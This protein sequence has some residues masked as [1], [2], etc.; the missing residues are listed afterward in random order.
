VWLASLLL[1]WR[2]GHE[3][4][5]AP[6]FIAL[7]FGSRVVGVHSPEV[8]LPQ[9]IQWMC[10]V[11]ILAGAPLLFLRTRCLHLARLDESTRLA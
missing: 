6:G 4:W 10:V 7:V 3:L 8:P 2:T 9:A 1:A 5:F 11:V